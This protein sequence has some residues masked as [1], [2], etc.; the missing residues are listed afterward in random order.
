M[1]SSTRSRRGTAFWTPGR[2]ALAAL[3][4]LTL[5]FIFGNTRRTEIRLLIPEVAMPLWLALF[6]TAVIG[7]LCGF[8]FGRRR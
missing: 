8:Y 1:T 3:G 4:V 2:V 5:I 6:A 7:G